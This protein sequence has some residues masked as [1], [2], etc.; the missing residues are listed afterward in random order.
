MCFQLFLEECKYVTKEKKMPIFIV[1]DTEISSDE[2]DKEE[3]TMK[4]TLMKKTLM[5]RTLMMKTLQT[6]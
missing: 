1:E 2:S 3:N 6:T 5:T 4:K